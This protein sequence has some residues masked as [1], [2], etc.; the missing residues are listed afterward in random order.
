M[1]IG[2]YRYPKSSKFNDIVRSSAVQIPNVTLET[3]NL[4][5][6]SCISIRY[7][8]ESTHTTKWVNVYTP[9]N[10]ETPFQQNNTVAEATV[11]LDSIQNKFHMPKRAR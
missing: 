10:K 2:R 11:A 5:K 3:F 4:T 9:S 8:I 1:L 7:K 6:N